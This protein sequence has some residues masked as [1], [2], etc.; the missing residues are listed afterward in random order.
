[1]ED[2]GDLVHLGL[3]KSLPPHPP[4]GHLLPRGE[5]GGAAAH[6]GSMC[7]GL[8]QLV[9]WKQYLSAAQFLLDGLIF[10]D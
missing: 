10:K 8:F 3:P 2:S 4:S 7:F 5:G 6:K 1:M 9:L